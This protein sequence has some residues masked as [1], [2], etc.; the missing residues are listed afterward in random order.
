VPAVVADNA[1]IG[2]LGPQWWG[3]TALL[4]DLD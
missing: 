3:K 4:R 1:I 2:V